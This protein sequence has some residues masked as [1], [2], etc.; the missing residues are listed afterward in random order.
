MPETLVQNPIWK[1][2]SKRTRYERLRGQLEIERFSFLDHWRQISTNLLPHRPLF[3][4]TDA[5]RGD[6]K[7]LSILDSTGTYASQVLTSG[8]MAAKTNPAKPWVR[9]TVPYAA[10]L[11][12]PTV[13]VWLHEVT[14]Q[15]LNLFLRTNLYTALPQLYRDA[16]GFGTGVMMIE[17]NREQVIKGKVI[18]VGSYFLALDNEDRVRVFMREY[19]M[20]VRQMIKEFGYDFPDD[21]IHWDRFSDYVKNMWS[22][23]SFDTWVDVVHV[24]E[25]SE[26]YTPDALYAKDSKPFHSCYYERGTQNGRWQEGY[27]APGKNETLL[28]ESGYD[29]F[30][31]LAFRWSTRDGDVYGVDC[32]GM[33]ALG[34]IRMLQT[35]ESRGLK[36]LEK[37]I[38][39]PLQAP[40]E[41]K[42]EKISLIP[43]DTTY[44]S[45]Y[46][47]SPGVRPIHEVRFGIKELKE[48]EYEVR[49]RILQAFSVNIILALTATDRRDI[50]ATEVEERREE[51][52]LALADVDQRIDQDIL[53][54][55]IDIVFDVLL[56]RGEIPP[57]PPELQGMPLKVEYVSSLSQAMKAVGIVGLERLAGF[58]VQ[59][60]QV[61]PDTLDVIDWDKLIRDY[62][63]KAGAAPQIILSPEI[64][65]EVRAQ[66]AEQVQKQQA[67][68]NIKEGS[69][70]VKNLAQSPTGED[71][72]NAL[73]SIVNA[74]QQG[75]AA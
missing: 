11:E 34:D 26:T 23:G 75:E 53:N 54:P 57:P 6:R 55:L 46:Q 10:L 29:Y 2:E 74:S 61:K 3:Q 31:I 21:E 30:P 1:S 52:L 49:E 60:A 35:M 69:A 67:I 70:A 7:N 45:S 37:M 51:K 18:P 14:E 64:V 47:N 36:A 71:E 13:K 17:E 24:I 56:R 66:R 43:G 73:T 41:L 22:Q 40:I 32:P 16:A 5:N 68:M 62:A 42:N 15:I 48:W 65:A 44:I 4:T 58:A 28:K 39:P 33:T 27:F 8:M 63:D 19:R 38:N 25:P 72:E 9:M 20:T 50:T 59:L 12:I